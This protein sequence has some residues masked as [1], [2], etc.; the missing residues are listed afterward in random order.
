MLACT[1]ILCRSV[2]ARKCESTQLTRVHNQYF[3]MM[4]YNCPES[5][6]RLCWGE[7]QYCRWQLWRRVTAIV[8]MMASKCNLWMCEKRVVV[9]C[10][11]IIHALWWGGWGLVCTTL[12][13][14][15]G[16]SLLCSNKTCNE[17]LRLTHFSIEYL[18]QHKINVRKRPCV[19]Y[20][21]LAANSSCFVF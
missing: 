9:L 16:V 11:D 4:L 3:E 14:A 12:A 18:E 19:G 6:G 10:A 5:F 17:I 13:W 21:A 7:L 2:R 1:P 20:M 8:K 15:G